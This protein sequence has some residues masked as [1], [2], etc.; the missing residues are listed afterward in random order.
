MNDPIARLTQLMTQKEPANKKDSHIDRE[1]I[2]QSAIAV[3]ECVR[4]SKQREDD[5]L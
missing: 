5:Q 1:K 2:L 4:D 3:S